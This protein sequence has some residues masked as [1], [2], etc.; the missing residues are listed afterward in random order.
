MTMFL[1]SGRSYLFELTAEAVS[2]AA[3]G[4]TQVHPHNGADA[5]MAGLCLYYSLI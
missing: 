2:A 1:E 5:S 3:E 4:E